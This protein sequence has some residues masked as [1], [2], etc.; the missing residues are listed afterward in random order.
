MASASAFA[1]TVLH[2]VAQPVAQQQGQ[3]LVPQ[4]TLVLKVREYLAD[5]LTL[6][7]ALRS[8][9]VIDN[10]AARLVMRCIF[11]T[12]DLPQQLEVHR[13][14]QLTPLNISIIHKTIEHVLLTTE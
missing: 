5:E 3:T 7:T 4:D 9:S 1:L 10:Q 2:D 6:A 11:T 14:E 8:I 12:T 13:I